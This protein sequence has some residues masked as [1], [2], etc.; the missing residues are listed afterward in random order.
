MLKVKMAESLCSRAIHRQN[1]LWSGKVYEKIKEPKA[2]QRTK[3]ECS[4]KRLSERT[5]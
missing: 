2:N 1:G 3:L 4:N 5:D